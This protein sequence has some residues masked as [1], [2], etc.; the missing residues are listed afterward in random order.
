MP[1]YNW[2]VR[3]RLQSRYNHLYR[4]YQPAPRRVCFYCGDPAETVDHVPPLSYVAQWG[5]DLLITSGI[6]FLLVESC[7]ECN[8]LLSNGPESTILDR[9]DLV[10]EK[11]AKRYKKLLRL[12]EWS[13]DEIEALGPSMRKYVGDPNMALKRIKRRLAWTPEEYLALIPW[14]DSEAA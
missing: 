4:P 2:R 6:S 11:L 10:K 9:A 7:G 1:K 14:G 5:S 13:Q 8:G 12:P 3:Q